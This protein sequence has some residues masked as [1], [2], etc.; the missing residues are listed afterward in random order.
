MTNI[1][2]ISII[3]I[4]S[5]HPYLLHQWINSISYAYNCLSWSNSFTPWWN[6]DTAFEISWIHTGLHSE[7]DRPVHTGDGLPCYSGRHYL[8]FMFTNYV[9][10]LLW[11]KVF[12][13]LGEPWSLL[14]SNFPG[15]LYG[16]WLVCEVQHPRDQKQNG[17]R[18]HCWVSEDA[19][20]KISNANMWD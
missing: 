5:S 8:L 7:L 19:H 6:P 15:F 16:L 3:H 11:Y 2:H 20:E 10:Q 18:G 13:L 1:G 17:A 14:L 9:Y 12:S 4:G